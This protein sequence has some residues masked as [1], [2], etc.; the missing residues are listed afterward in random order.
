MFSIRTERYR[1]TEWG[2]TTENEGEKLY[3]Y[4]TDPDENRQYSKSSG[5]TQN[6]SRSSANNFG[7]D[8]EKLY[9]ISKNKFLSYK[10]LPWDINDDGVVNIQDLIL[11]SKQLW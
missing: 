5:K 7:Q 4:D 2:K 10:T 6:S 11:V 1:Y 3:D 8:G 9:Q